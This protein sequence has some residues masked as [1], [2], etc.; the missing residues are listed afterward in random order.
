M[1]NGRS[2]R[3]SKETAKERDQPARLTGR[4]AGVYSGR[5]GRGDPRVRPDHHTPR[6]AVQLSLYAKRH[7]AKMKNGGSKG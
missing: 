5:V 6:K 2:A 3:Q 1:I 4:E 7:V